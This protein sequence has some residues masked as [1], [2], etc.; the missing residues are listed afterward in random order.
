M[1]HTHLK[2]EDDAAKKMVTQ[3]Q[4]TNI[5]TSRAEGGGMNWEPGTEV[6]TLMYKT[7]D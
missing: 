1:F 5:W 6:Y 3:S 4:R 7:D 2:S